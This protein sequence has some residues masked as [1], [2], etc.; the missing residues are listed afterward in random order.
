MKAK[1]LNRVAKIIVIKCAENKIDT[2]IYNIVEVTC[3]LLI[4]AFEIER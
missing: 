4:T 2:D 3:V 1:L